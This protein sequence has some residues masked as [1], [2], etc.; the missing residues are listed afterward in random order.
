MLTRD[1]EAIVPQGPTVLNEGDILTLLA[2]QS[3]AAEIRRLCS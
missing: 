3:E 2:S 1:D